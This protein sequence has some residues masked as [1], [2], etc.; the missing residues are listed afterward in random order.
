MTVD[1]LKN[2]FDMKWLIT[3][4]KLEKG[5]DVCK[6]LCIDFR[7]FLF[8]V[9]E[10]LLFIVPIFS[11]EKG[12]LVEPE[13]DYTETQATVNGGH[14]ERLNAFVDVSGAKVVAAL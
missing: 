6:R 8:L 2:R 1:D 13:Y 5:V 10:R 12:W 11:H 3:A 9:P 4:E 7:G 14:A